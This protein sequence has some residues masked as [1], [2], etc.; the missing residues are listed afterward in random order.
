MCW[1]IQCIL[2]SPG[3]LRKPLLNKSFSHTSASGSNK[4]CINE[5]VIL[6]FFI[7]L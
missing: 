4:H 3:G 7:I 6:L 2:R 1:E 5:Q